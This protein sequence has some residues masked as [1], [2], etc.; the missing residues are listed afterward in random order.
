[1]VAINLCTC[2]TMTNTINKGLIILWAP[3]RSRSTAFERMIIE[4]GDF[5]V[6]H[7]PFSTIYDTGELLIKYDDGGAE[8][9]FNSYSEVMRWIQQLSKERLV[10]IK[11]TCEYNY[12]EVFSDKPFLD[13]AQHAFLVRD[14]GEII[15]S[16]YKMNPRVKPAEIGYEN[17]S[18]LKCSLQD[19]GKRFFKID[20]Q[21]LVEET[22]AAILK[23]CK[24]M[25]IP[26]IR[27]ALTWEAG[28][29]EIWKR[30]NLWHKGAENSTGF[31][32]TNNVYEVTI[33]N[34]SYL[35]E[36]YSYNL[37]FYRQFL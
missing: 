6:F 17:L 7:E 14:L 22:E 19:L 1:V 13:C 2:C 26:F 11:E 8:R 15:A 12:R 18:M 28:Q 9:K 30:T 32:R 35:M 5:L 21:E 37:P 34:S 25:S 20:S 33:H 29:P 36:L 31:A 10:F 16:H 4:R 3:P 27:S 23:F 24:Y